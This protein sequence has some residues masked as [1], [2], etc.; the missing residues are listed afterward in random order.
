MAFCFRGRRAKHRDFADDIAAV[1]IQDS[2]RTIGVAEKGTGRGGEV[3]LDVRAVVVVAG[4]SP[5]FLTERGLENGRLPGTENGPSHAPVMAREGYA[6]GALDVV[7]GTEVEGLKIT[8][9]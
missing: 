2:A 4:I 5:V 9:M 1:P 3:T 8:F 7:S 6:V